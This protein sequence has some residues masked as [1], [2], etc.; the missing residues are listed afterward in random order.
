MARTSRSGAPSANVESLD[1]FNLED[2]FAD[3]GDELFDGLD[4]DLGN[5][6][7]ITGGNAQLTAA[8]NANASL[9]RPT[10][11]P[12]PQE[13]ESLPKRRTTKR[14]TKSRF[15]YEDDED[16]SD[17]PA[18]KKSRTSK[19]A[20]TKKRT[21]KKTSSVSAD[22]ASPKASATSK[23]KSKK[24]ASSSVE[25]SSVASSVA[26]SGQF[27]GRQNKR[28]SSFTAKG[29]TKLPTKKAADGKKAKTSST[30]SDTASSQT[31]AQPSP[32][33]V[34][35]NLSQI[36][37]TH[38]GLTQG[39]FC[40]LLPSD[41]LFY[42]FLPALPSETAMKSRKVFGLI[43]RIHSSFL[44]HI[45]G[46]KTP[47][48]TPNPARETD[49]IFK[50]IQEAYKL[51]PPSATTPN[52]PD[53]DSGRVRTIG[54]TVGLL[55]RTIPLFDRARLAADLYAVCALL[56]RQHDFLKQNM[57]NMEK[58]CRQYL[59]P[60]EYASVYLSSK[61]KKRKALEGEPSV[62]VLQQL[63]KAEV[64]VKIVISAGFKVPK[65]SAPLVALLP[66]PYGPA[67]QPAN[68][69]RK[70]SSESQ[71]SSVV[72]TSATVS[73]EKSVPYSECRPVRRR[74]YIA[75]LVART[76]RELE[77]TYQQKL[78]EGKQMIFRQESEVQKLA[79]EN[80]TSGALHTGG[81]WRW[82]EKST[83]FAS[84]SVKEAQS[85]LDSVRHPLPS[86]D[87][88][89]EE[90]KEPSVKHEKR[91]PMADSSLADRLTS[92]LV[93]EDMSDDGEEEIKSAC[94]DQTLVSDEDLIE[95]IDE[96]EILVDVSNLSLEERA[97][98]HL[99][100]FGL[101]GTEFLTRMDL[102]TRSKHNITDSEGDT[103]SPRM[104]LMKDN[105]KGEE[106]DHEENGMDEIGSDVE[107]LIRQMVANLADIT[108]TNNK[109]ANFLESL[110][111]C[112][113]Q[114]TEKSKPKKDEEASL[115]AKC[116][117]IIKKGRESKVKAVRVKSVTKS[118]ES[119]LPW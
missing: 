18:Q 54:S 8:A 80:D 37:S 22:D 102:A 91:F 105:D 64:K 57:H 46:A 68:K 108:C 44:S 92:L 29:R 82:L 116:Q 43:D 32:N 53:G 97:S 111:L 61:S 16:Y 21:N 59:P 101:V 30:A 69:K 25:T 58:W 56:K 74:K 6:D 72:S 98:I 113:N 9:T 115:I 66:P 104:D 112:S 31:S 60:D 103:G 40:G 90:R 27:G 79:I 1:N 99:H 118:D 28:G 93:E 41:T 71:K 78:D 20:A 100:A 96:K 39:P 36:M 62:S 2:M 4:I 65:G 85:R 95:E 47:P 94:E 12:P 83:Y 26:A 67:R 55:R 84:F 15:A 88:E 86:D 87:W 35:Q 107:E 24:K 119:A 48:A 109:R 45:Q 117:Q 11:P 110:A 63:N 5:M 51:P 17:A 13:E 114:C 76:A 106:Q 52:A 38:T 89:E 49:P 3:G 75:D 42:P 81:M 14:K 70:L 77:A 73:R 23:G 10:R 19:A 7:D 34:L 50:L 33:N